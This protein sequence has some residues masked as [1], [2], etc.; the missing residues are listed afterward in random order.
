MT[1]ESKDFY[2]S[3][4]LKHT[5]LRKEHLQSL[6]L[7]ELYD[8]YCERVLDN[9]MIKKK[10]WVLINIFRDFTR[11]FIIITFVFMGI[12]EFLWG[13]GVS[14]TTYVMSCIVV[15]CSQAELAI[16]DRYKV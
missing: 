6:N 4:L 1:K 14:S 15:V 12:F 10:R 8:L 2:I 7:K 16:K 11:V 13:Y 5:G 3:E 9:G